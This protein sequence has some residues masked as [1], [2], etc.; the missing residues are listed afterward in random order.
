MYCGTSHS[1]DPKG[2]IRGARKSVLA[3][4]IPAAIAVAAPALQ[5]QQ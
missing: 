2:F 1:A 3:S 5:P 4:T